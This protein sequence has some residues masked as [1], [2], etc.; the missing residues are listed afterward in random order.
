[1]TNGGNFR[2]LRAAGIEPSEIDT[3]I[4]THAHPDHLSGMLDEEERLVFG[5]A[6]YFISQEE[7]DF[8]NSDDARTKV[9]IFMVDLGGS[10]SLTTGLSS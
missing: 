8:W 4:T 2:Y 9:P 1:M 3:V 5:D 6:H 10:L 7:W